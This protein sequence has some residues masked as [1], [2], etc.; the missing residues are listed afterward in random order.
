M[1]GVMTN[2]TDQ[3]ILRASVHIIP[4]NVRFTEW[5]G[6]IRTHLLLRRATRHVAIGSER[7][8]ARRRW[9]EWWLA[10]APRPRRFALQDSFNLR[11]RRNIKQQTHWRIDQTFEQVVR[12]EAARNHGAR[13]FTR[14]ASFQNRMHVIDKVYPF[15]AIR[16]HL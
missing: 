5:K 6:M 3:E 16:L 14:R 12:K 10:D 8:A 11:M 7:A 4:T 9:T 1:H 15:N 13:E 2:E